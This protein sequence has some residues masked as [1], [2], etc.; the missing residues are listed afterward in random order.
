MSCMNWLRQPGV[1]DSAGGPPLDA[2]QTIKVKEIQVRGAKSSK[3]AL[4]VSWVSQTQPYT[5]SRYNG[6]KKETH[7][8][9]VDLN[10]P[11]SGTIT[12]QLLHPHFTR[13]DTLLASLEVLSE[14]LMGADKFKFEKS[15]KIHKTSA[16]SD[17]ILMIVIE[18]E[19]NDTMKTGIEKMRN[20][21][22]AVEKAMQPVAPV[23]E[24][25][26]NLAEMHD[27]ARAAWI[28]VS[29][30]YKVV[31]AYYKQ[32][33]EIVD[34]YDAMIEAYKIVEDNNGINQAGHFSEVFEEIVRQSEECNIFLSKTISKDGTRQVIDF[35][36]TSRKLEEFT[37]AFKQLKAKFGETQTKVTTASVL[38]I[39]K[40]V[41]YLVQQQR[42]QPL[43]A[44]GKRPL[45]SKSHC[46][47][48]TCRESLKAIVDWIFHGDEQQSIL[49][50]SGI[51]GVGKSSLIGTLYNSLAQYGFSSHLA[52]FICFDRADYQDAKALI[53]SLAFQLAKFD[54]HF[55]NQIADAVDRNPRI[56]DSTDMSAQV[57]KLIINP[58]INLKEEIAKEGCVVVMIDGI[59]ECSHSD[60]AETNFRKQMLQLFETNKLELLPFLCIV[61]AS[62]PEEDIY[63]TRKDIKFFF[64]KCLGDSS[65]NVLTKEEKEKALT[66]LPEHASG[67]FI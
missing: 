46:L 67:L 38:D 2:A 26:G 62:R 13:K 8:W 42:L 7:N 56:I 24:V 29:G 16:G 22:E 32:N 58:L 35:W 17:I 36:A 54:E 51:A 45:G 44:A 19:D 18:T 10:I 49:W 37:I 30:V 23:L 53:C 61:L 9:P 48:G 3:I 33:S 59:D 41:D 1:T 5:T 55:G 47:L 50:I 57:Q 4:N 25:L 52:A 27:I 43:N 40:G 66:L 6:N 12:F 39:R 15:M 11:S 21:T 14:E 60:H 28:A 20:R 34:L 64:E 65:F 63:E 31:E